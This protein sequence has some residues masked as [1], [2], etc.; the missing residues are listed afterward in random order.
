VENSSYYGKLHLISPDEAERSAGARLDAVNEEL[1]L[2][3][4]AQAER[5][6]AFAATK[7]QAER[8]ASH[9]KAGRGRC[10]GTR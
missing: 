9:W 10:P 4:K 3:E 6:R 8:T 5:D 7:D 1:A 2:L